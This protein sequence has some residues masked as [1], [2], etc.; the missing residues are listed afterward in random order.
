[1]NRTYIIINE[2]D[3]TMSILEEA[4]EKEGTYRKNLSGSQA[5]LMFS[6]AH[7]DC[8]AGYT[9]YTLDEIRAYLETNKVVWKDTT[10]II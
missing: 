1:M 2:S 8:V 4:I 10:V 6:D 3:I 5:V 7:P 9:K